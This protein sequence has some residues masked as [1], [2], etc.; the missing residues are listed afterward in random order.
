MDKISQ[1]SAT[2][3][4]WKTYN[5]MP[6]KTTALDRIV[7]IEKGA[8]KAYIDDAIKQA[9]NSKAI[10]AKKITGGNIQKLEAAK[11]QQS[12]AFQSNLSDLKQFMGKGI[13]LDTYV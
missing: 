12:K 6:S 7:E 2:S 3:N 4:L 1:V 10:N 8:E 9:T 13:N 11:S 5:N